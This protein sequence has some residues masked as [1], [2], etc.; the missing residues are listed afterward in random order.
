MNSGKI[1]YEL[2]NNGRRIIDVSELERAFGIRSTTEGQSG[3]NAEQEV[4]K[5]AESRERERMKTRSKML[6]EQLDLSKEQLDDLRDQRD[7]W[8]KQAQQVLLTSQYSQKQAETLQ[9][10]VK[11]FERKELERRR[12][13]AEARM[14]RMGAENQNKKNA[15]ASARPMTAPVANTL[16]KAK[17]DVQGLWKKIKG[18]AATG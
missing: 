14:K 1:S 7:Q 10:E 12:M 18:E 3:D 8:Q 4:K 16:D 2:D 9:A 15:P 5:S 17:M 13:A 6:E 11:E